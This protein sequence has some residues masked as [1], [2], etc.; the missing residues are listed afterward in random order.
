MTE[1]GNKGGQR[2]VEVS[3]AQDE[4]DRTGKCAT[5]AMGTA[6]VNS[7]ARG[8]T[9]VTHT[10]DSANSGC[11]SA[12][13]TVSALQR[14]YQCLLQRHDHSVT[15]ALSKCLLQRHDHIVTAA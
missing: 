8:A 13:I 5:T 3:A 14:H 9:L 4:Y 1:R 7:R 15:A 10:T 6:A 12:S 2:G 11:Y